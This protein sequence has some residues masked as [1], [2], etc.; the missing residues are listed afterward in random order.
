ML[1]NSGILAN[2][3]CY[4]FFSRRQPPSLLSPENTHTSRAYGILAIWISEGRLNIFNCVTLYQCCKLKWFIAVGNLH[5]ATRS[6]PECRSSECTDLIA[7]G[8][9][10]VSWTFTLCIFHVRLHS[11]RIYHLDSPANLFSAYGGTWIF[12]FLKLSIQ[13]GLKIVRTLMLFAICNKFWT[14]YLC[15]YIMEAFLCVTPTIPSD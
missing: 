11:V 12:L 13:F 1:I 7:A 8:N 14:Y 4:T 5:R 15:N 6:V 3:L 10:T 2:F 9:D